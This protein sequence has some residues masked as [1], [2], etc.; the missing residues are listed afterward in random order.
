MP[1]GRRSEMLALKNL[2]DLKFQ[3]QMCRVM[4]GTLRVGLMRTESESGQRIIIHPKE[5]WDLNR[6]CEELNLRAEELKEIIKRVGPDLE[7]I[8][9]YLARRN[10]KR[11]SS[12]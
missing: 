7:N 8:R 12:F 9:D 10:M 3:V 4:Y 6:W 2:T 5:G 1:I 11:E